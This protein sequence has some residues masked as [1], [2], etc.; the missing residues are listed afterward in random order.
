M[1]INKIKIKYE[2]YKNYFFQKFFLF[3][4]IN[5]LNLTKFVFLSCVAI[6]FAIPFYLMIILS[7]KSMKD[8]INENPLSLPKYGYFFSNYKEVF[9]GQFA[10]FKYFCNTLRMVFFSTL[11]GTFCCILTAFALSHLNFRMKNVILILLILSLMIA[12]ETLV[13]SN[14]RTVANLGW[15]NTGKNSSIPFGVDLAMILP[16]LNNTVHTLLLVKT[17][18]RVPKELYYTSRVDGANNWYYLWKILIPITKSTIIITIIFRIVAAWNA[19]AWPELVGAELLTNMLRKKFDIETEI[20]S[21]NIQM[22]ASVLINLPLFFIFVFFKKY[23]IS[24]E[25]NSGIKG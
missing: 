14:F 1:S 17:F 9:S 5:F 6:F 8:I 19:Y 12:S 13:L 15:V 20:S 18:E 23:I 24:G 10:F 2:K 11:A 7:I 25:S 3:K 21:V 22:S 16:Y 4:K